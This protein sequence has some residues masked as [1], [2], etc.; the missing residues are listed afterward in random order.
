[1]SKCIDRYD[2]VN[3]NDIAKLILVLNAQIF[4]MEMLCTVLCVLAQGI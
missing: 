2:Y 3:Y 4:E 1:M